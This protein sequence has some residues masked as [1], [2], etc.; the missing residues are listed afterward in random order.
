MSDETRQVYRLRR[1]NGVRPA[2]ADSSAIV[3]VFNNDERSPHAAT[4]HYK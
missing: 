3:F 1:V 2:A 4:V